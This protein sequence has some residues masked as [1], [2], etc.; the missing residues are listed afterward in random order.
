MMLR[1]KDKILRSKKEA[2]IEILANNTSLNEKEIR[3]CLF[4]SKLARRTAFYFPILFLKDFLV[5]GAYK[6]LRPV[7]TVALEMRALVFAQLYSNVF[8]KE[9]APE[10]ASYQ[11]EQASKLLSG[12][13]HLREQAVKVLTKAPKNSHQKEKRVITTIL[14]GLLSLWGRVDPMEQ[15][16]SAYLADYEQ[17]LA[18]VILPFGEAYLKGETQP[19]LILKDLKTRDEGFFAP[20]FEGTS[21]ELRNAIA[22]RNYSIDKTKAAFRYYGSPY[23]TKPKVIPLSNLTEM[24]LHQRESPALLSNQIFL[25]E[26][27][28]SQDYVNHVQN[29]MIQSVLC[30]LNASLDPRMRTNLV[31]YAYSWLMDSRIEG[32]PFVLH[33]LIREILLLTPHDSPRHVFPFL[34]YPDPPTELP[35][36]P[37]LETQTEKEIVILGKEIFTQLSSKK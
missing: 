33:H 27:T 36:L 24:I 16:L 11:R 35:E 15:L 26:Q 30:T 29:L 9:T 4:D 34:P 19:D 31:I 7:P 23:W 17:M 22:H 25:H 37:P 1:D 20:L 12:L 28:S 14:D 13:R 10:V 21:R 32:I 18:M 3:T 2:F 6:T 8:W 5:T